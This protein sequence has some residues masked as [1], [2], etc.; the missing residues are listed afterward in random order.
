MTEFPTSLPFVS[1]N[2]RPTLSFRDNWM[3]K[4]HRSRDYW[5]L[6]FTYNDASYNILIPFNHS[7]DNLEPIIQVYIEGDDW[8]GETS[9]QR[10]Q[11]HNAIIDH[12]TGLPDDADD[13]YVILTPA[14][15]ARV[16]D[17]LQRFQMIRH[18]VNL[19]I[20]H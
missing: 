12:E 2:F 9:Q 15:I 11:R 14:I 6:A 16:D 7:Y 5:M 8:I 4:S 10:T 19:A 3:V 18:I 13:D 17:C 20:C 1:S